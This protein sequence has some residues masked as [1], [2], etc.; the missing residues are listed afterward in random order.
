MCFSFTV[1]LIILYLNELPSSSPLPLHNSSPLLHMYQRLLQLY[2]T[3][4]LDTYHVAG[5]LIITE[6]APFPLKWMKVIKQI[7]A[8][9]SYTFALP[10]IRSPHTTLYS[11]KRSC[12]LRKTGYDISDFSMKWESKN[13]P[14]SLRCSKAI[15]ESILENRTGVWVRTAPTSTCISMLGPQ[16]VWDGVD[17][18]ALFK[19]VCVSL[20]LGFRFAKPRSSRLGLPVP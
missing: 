15:T 16:T 1:L 9:D 14:Y 7:W 13:L 12:F 4:S 2:Y 6:I 20:E 3:V 11:L 18:V 5:F 10:L 8:D 19:G 17:G